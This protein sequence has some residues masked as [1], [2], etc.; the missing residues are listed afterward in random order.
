MSAGT[1]LMLEQLR[2]WAGS[3]CGGGPSDDGLLERFTAG[4]SAALEA[5]VARHGPMVLRVCR[6]TVRDPD[7]AEDAFQATF[8]VLARRAP[9]LHGRGSLAG[10]LY[11]VARH[12]ALR[13]V[14]SAGRL[15]SPAADAPARAADPLAEMTARELLRALDEELARLPECYRMPLVLCYLEGKTRDDAARLLGVTPGV[16]K[17]RLER[18]RE[19]LRLRLAK[20][21]L[22]LPAVLLAAGSCVSPSPGAPVPA[23]LSSATLRGVLARQAS[24]RVDALARATVAWRSPALARAVLVLAVA[25][26][27]LAAG[28]ARLAGQSAPAQPSGPARHAVNDVPRLDR[29]GDPLPAGAIVRLG[30]TRLR[31]SFTIYSVHF[32]PD[33]KLLATT[34]GNST[35]RRL[36][37]WDAVTGKLLHDIPAP[38]DVMDVSF[39]PGANTLAAAVYGWT[40]VYD[41]ATGAEVE[42]FTGPKDVLCVAYSPDGAV[43]ASG[44]SDGTV[45][46]RDR[47][48]RELRSLAGDKGI[49]RHVAFAPDGKAVA[50]V[51]DDGSVRVWDS[52]TGVQ[53]WCAAAHP[54]GALWVAYASDGK[55]L[56]TGGGDG[57]A[58][59]RDAA[60][61][62]LLHSFEPG[63]KDPSRP[64]YKGYVWSLAYSPDGKSMAYVAGDRYVRIVDP[65]TGMELRRWQAHSDF[66]RALA[67]SPDGKT[68][69]SA[70]TFG[71][72]VR[73]W[74]PETGKEIRPREGHTS[75][76]ELAAMSR[77][78][79]Q[80]W[81]IGRDDTLFR[82]DVATG[83]GSAVANL[84]R[85]PGAYG[86]FNATAVSPDRRLLATA[87]RKEGTIRL[88]D[89][90]SGKEVATLG[91]HEGGVMG[92]AFSADGKLLASGGT[93][94]LVCL[95]D[96][97]ARREVKRLVP[98]VDGVASLAFSPDGKRI[99]TGVCDGERGAP[100]GWGIRLW[101]LDTGKVLREFGGARAET[102]AVAFSPDGKLVASGNGWV[103]HKRYGDNKVHV[104]DAATGEAVW[105]GEGHTAGVAGV[106]FSP[107]GRLLASGGV[108]GEG[109]VRLWETATG[110]EVA[111]FVGNHA[112]VFSLTFSADGTKLTSGGG[113]GT[114]VVWDVTGQVGGG[115]R[116]RPLSP[117]RLRAAWEVLRSVDGK[118][119]Q[120]AVWE[121][122]GSPRAS[123]PYLAER[124]RPVPRVDSEECARLVARLD[125]AAF[126]ER[127]RAAAELERLGEAV[128]PFLAKTL[129]GDPTP[130][131][132][133]RLESLRDKLS[134]S[135]D[136]LRARRAVQV[137]E[138]AGTPEARQLLEK[139]AGGAEGDRLTEEAR[140]ALARSGRR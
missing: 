5:L 90:A 29:S 23:S 37:L 124:L 55:T 11:T 106:A 28:M 69:A 116:G 127:E 41:V 45:I 96:V 71:S 128:I 121:L 6:R 81:S 94:S 135:P 60:S 86:W 49:A 22:A 19:R 26:G 131:V 117:G 34:G 42:R 134:G 123:V 18:G 33:G 139:L 111:N 84:P 50:A 88:W 67:Y 48:G 17:G 43:L 27:G 4:D 102:V 74:D 68:L 89:T 30:T 92:L 3:G 7:A 114:L 8:L 31:H 122:A 85:M 109:S 9:A 24:P 91:K 136:R 97:V 36:C 70:A 57:R 140:S 118:A 77:D 105:L 44:G 112:G 76:A 66:A 61:G 65:S 108:E 2:E 101:D 12:L 35:G 130:E 25:A 98:S 62:R 103:R 20:R 73:L 32:S 110:S 56:A 72:A 79:K 133:R 107:D 59:L 99:I 39:T 100:A 52:A 46:L 82:W 83:C 54:G 14:A 63:P 58:A 132:R 115:G 120:Q 78:G 40:I 104:W 138:F 51:A 125:A 38:N 53:H 80:V 95:W 137:L 126:A 1:N 21:G 93:A 129:A 64:D 47:K 119:A 16:V 113:D 75:S 13:S 10:W 87:H 15:R